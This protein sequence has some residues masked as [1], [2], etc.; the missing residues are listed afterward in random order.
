MLRPLWTTMSSYSS[1]GQRRPGRG[2]QMAATLPAAQ[3]LPPA[4]LRSGLALK[5]T[6]PQSQ[7]SFPA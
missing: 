1:W 5:P 3:F 2:A 6:F 7:F 4:A